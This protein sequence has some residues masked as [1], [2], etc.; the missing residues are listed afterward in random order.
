MNPCVFLDRDGV[1]NA[2][3]GTYTWQL[4]DFEIIPGVVKALELLKKTGYL[5]VVVTNQSGVSKGLYTKK[6]MEACHVY[7][8][9]QTRHL[10]D[11]IYYATYHPEYSNSLLRKPDSLMFEKAI[12][13]HHIDPAD[14]W[15]IGDNERDMIP[16]DKLGIQTI[17]ITRDPETSHYPL[18]AE[19]LYEAVQIILQNQ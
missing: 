9:K 12:A 7:M 6:D 16:A 5:I 11:D 2:E 10:I 13:R 17:F 18:T 14:S 1:I 19:G 3:R 15:M 8:M 4:P